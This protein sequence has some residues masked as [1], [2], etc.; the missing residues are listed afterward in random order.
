[1]ALR[2]HS[3]S[4]PSQ[5]TR[6]GSSTRLRSPRSAL[7]ESRSA[8]RSAPVISWAAT[9][10][11]TDGPWNAWEAN[12]LAAGPVPASTSTKTLTI[13]PPSLT[14]PNVL[15]AYQRVRSVSRMAVSS[16]TCQAR[17]TWAPGTRPPC[18]PRVNPAMWV[19]FVARLVP[20]A[21]ACPE[22]AVRVLLVP[23][24]VLSEVARPWVS[25]R[26]SMWLCAWPAD[27]TCDWVRVQLRPAVSVWLRPRAWL[28]LVARPSL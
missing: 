4:V 26:P 1:M 24:A 23:V 8:S 22:P 2:V 5:A 21:T 19:A 7:S 12:A 13:Q 9:G 28:S 11:G 25:V 14:A 18:R 20:C 17:P 16:S 27:S 3:S 6:S 10:R 15:L